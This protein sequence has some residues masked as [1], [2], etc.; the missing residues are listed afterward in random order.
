[1]PSQEHDGR[2]QLLTPYTDPDRH[3]AQRYRQTDRQTD[4]SIMPRSDHTAC[5][6]NITIGQTGFSF[7]GVTVRLCMSPDPST[8]TVTHGSLVY[9]IMFDRLKIAV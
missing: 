5:I 7:Y 3:N 2:L 6:S 8:D 9:L 1:M 4:D